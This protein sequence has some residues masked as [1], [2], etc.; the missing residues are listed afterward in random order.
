MTYASRSAAAA[1]FTSNAYDWFEASNNT[2]ILTDILG[3]KSTISGTVVDFINCMQH[4][5]HSNEGGVSSDTH[6][7]YI[8]IYIYISD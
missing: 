3:Y 2:D 8:Y 5:G 4:V 6:T 7:G 1:D